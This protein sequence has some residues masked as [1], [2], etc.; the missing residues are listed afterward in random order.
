MGKGYEYCA[1]CNV[2]VKKDVWADHVKRSG[3]GC[4]KYFFLFEKGVDEMGVQLLVGSY[5]RRSSSEM[6]WR[7]IRAALRETK[8]EAL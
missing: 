6:E 3:N 2:F 5:Q 4:W 7:E 1:T 8:F